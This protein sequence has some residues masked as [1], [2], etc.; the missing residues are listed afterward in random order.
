MIGSGKIE[1]LSWRPR[2]LGGSILLLAAISCESRSTESA[3]P[4]T[5]TSRVNAAKVNAPQA[6]TTEAFCDGYFAGDRGP[7]FAWPAVTGGKAPAA[8][9][10]TWRWVNVW[11]TWCKPCIEEMPR[12]LRW[13][14]KLAAAG[15]P[16]ELAFISVDESDAEVDT[17][18]KSHPDVPPSVRIA[19]PAQQ[20]AWFGALGLD[21]AAPIP[22]HVFV[23]PS[24][25]TRCARAGGVRD[26]DYAVVERLLG[27]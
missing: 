8:S 1:F 10:S 2:R 24:G 20:A 25:K 14:D 6:A 23:A 19:D 9:G 16:I 15:K 5:P 12:L 27:E 22:V 21:A 26:Q 13:K 7:T 3:A 4:P 17:F 18:R 11:A